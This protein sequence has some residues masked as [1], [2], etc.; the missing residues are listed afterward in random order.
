M[1]KFFRHFRQAMIKD[2]RVSKYM[3]YAVGEIVLVVIGILIALQINNWN[4]AQKERALE[5]KTLK[6][7]HTSFV[8][9]LKDIDYNL[10]LHENGR[11]A[12][13]QLLLAFSNDLPY[14]DSLD[15]YFGQFY[16]VSV[17]VHSTGAYETLKSRGMDIITN[18]SL[19]KQVVR[20]H[21][22]IYNE[23]V[24]NQNNFDFVDLQENKRFM[25]EHMTDWK[26]FQTAKPRD[27]NKISTNSAFRNRLEYTVQSRTMMLDRYL[28][29][30]KECEEVIS[31]LER[32]IERL[33]N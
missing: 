4:G 21:D 27:Y 22:L 17:F 15:Q 13:E 28:R 31:A 29:A 32:E 19:R 10:V 3:L 30:K 6:E 18:D 8:I 9:D 25:F 26:F 16:N 12:S 24:V 5:I 23:I 1:I 20:M 11:V 33:S 2:N 7:L 14:N